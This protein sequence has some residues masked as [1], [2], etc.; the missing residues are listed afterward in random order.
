MIPSCVNGT[1]VG[2][3]IQLRMKRRYEL[4]Y[5]VGKSSI[6]LEEGPVGSGR[7]ECLKDRVQGGGQDLFFS[8]LWFEIEGLI[9]HLVLLGEV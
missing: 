2:T 7:R 1:V 9:N 3:G 6:S 5:D 4:Y 8:P